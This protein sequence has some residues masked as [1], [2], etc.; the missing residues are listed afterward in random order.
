MLIKTQ[1]VGIGI[2]TGLAVSMFAA[3]ATAVER[4]DHI[5]TVASQESNDCKGVSGYRGQFWFGY[6]YAL[7][8]CETRSLI[9]AIGAGASLA[10]I[11]ALGTG[12]GAANA[13]IIGAIGGLTVAALNVCVAASSN[14]AI[15]LNSGV[16]PAIPV[17]CWGQ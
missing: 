5:E 8:S 7:N 15:Y 16:P 17:S 1:I 14:G 6:Q 12:P 9:A 2:A 10:S 4:E 13:A 3:P 11:G